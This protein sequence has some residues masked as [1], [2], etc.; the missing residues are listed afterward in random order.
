MSDPQ[1]RTARLKIVGLVIILIGV[2]ADLGSKAYFEDLL[3]MDPGH[4]RAE[5]RIE[6][7][8]GFLAWEGTYNPGVT[9]GL[10][11]D[12]TEVILVLTVLATL[13]LGF[14]FLKTGTRSRCLH[15]GLAMIISG[16]IGNLYDRF[17]WAKVR[18][19]ILVYLGEPGKESFKW[20]NFN[21][22]DTFIVVGVG[23]VMWDALFGLGAKE[24]KEAAEA[25]K[26]AKQTP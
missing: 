2:A 26:K 23:L 17:Q 25:K 22:A 11:A 7:I 20:P 3:G 18:D 14:W 4:R 21:L 16:A 5:R 9:F 15:V 13:G 12:Q 1:P 19:F 8:E 10:A 6:V 24:A